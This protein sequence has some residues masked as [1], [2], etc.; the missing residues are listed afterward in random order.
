MWLP[1]V[2]GVGVTVGLGVY[3]RLHEP[4]GTPVLVGLRDGKAWLAT[5]VLLFAVVQ[6]VSAT[7]MSKD[8]PWTP[9]LHR[10]S[11]RIAV[12]LSL[13]IAVHCL[14]AL[15]FGSA[16]LRT[17][18]HSTLGCFF[19]GA[20]VTKMLVLSRPGESPGWLLPLLGGLV[21]TAIAGLWLTSALW[22]FTAS[23]A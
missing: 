23:A 8:V 3:G 9:A 2:A 20:F 7:A 13:P 18:A 22:F 16:S 14:Y 10:W 1:V 15:G 11:G 19:Y 4:S 17:L 6:L 5:A 21:L 12:L